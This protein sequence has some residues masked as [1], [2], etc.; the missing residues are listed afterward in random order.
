MDGQSCFLMLELARV[1]DQEP[2]KVKILFL[3]SGLVDKRNFI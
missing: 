1:V 3:A 2:Q